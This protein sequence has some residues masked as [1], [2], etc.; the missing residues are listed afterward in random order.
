[1]QDPGTVALNWPQTIVLLL[2]LAGAILFRIFG[3][4][5]PFGT[6]L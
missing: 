3:L 2:V 4:R 6:L 5:L 1:M